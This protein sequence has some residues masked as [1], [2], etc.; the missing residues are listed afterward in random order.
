MLI[1][2][3]EM[4]DQRDY[5]TGN[6]L[7]CKG[8]GEGERE[9][10][11]EREAMIESLKS[12]DKISLSNMIFSKTDVLEVPGGGPAFRM[13]YHKNITKVPVGTRLNVRSVVLSLLLR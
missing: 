9:G 12:T 11:I 6:Q 13:C 10:E 1:C 8:Y 3:R 7:A 4:S 2:N 5:S